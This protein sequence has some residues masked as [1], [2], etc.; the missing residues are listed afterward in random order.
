MVANLP[1]LERM[2]KEK[3]VTAGEKTYAEF[4][5]L[6]TKFFGAEWVRKME[7]KQRV[8]KSRAERLSRLTAGDSGV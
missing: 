4:Q 2:R 7:E 1:K 8:K 5:T 3:R 6:W